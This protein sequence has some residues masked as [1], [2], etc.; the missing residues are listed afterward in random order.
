[1]LTT[2]AVKVSNGITSSLGELG[3]VKSGKCEDGDVYTLV[4]KALADLTFTPKVSITLDR[5]LILNVYIPASDA[6]TALKLAGNTVDLAALEVVELDGA[7]YYVI[8]TPMAASVAAGSLAMEATLTA[9]GASANKSYTFSV[10]RYAELV[11]AGDSEVEKQLVRDVLSYVRAAYAYFGTTDA[12]AMAAINAILGEG[13]DDDNAHA[14]EGNTE[15]VTPG[16]KGATLVLDATPA[17]RFYLEDGADVSAYTFYVDGAW[18]PVVT[19]TDTNGAYVEIDV[20]AYAMCGTVTYSVNGTA[21]GSYH[22]ASY[23]KYATE[24]GD[25]K[26]IALVDRMWKYFQSARAYRNSVLGA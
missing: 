11:L 7:E 20:Y 8:R 24:G 23:Y 1:M 26:L 21:A 25:A 4:N 9:G 6:L 18:V 2:S 17:I 3:F 13:Y 14:E 10:I 5:D 22:I 19:G 16:F 15:A 12:D